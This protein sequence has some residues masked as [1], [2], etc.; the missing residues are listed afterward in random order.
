MRTLPGS[1]IARARNA[2]MNRSMVG[3][4]HGLS[5]KPGLSATGGESTV[6]SGET[7]RTDASTDL[8]RGTAHHLLRRCVGYVQDTVMTLARRIT[9][10]PGPPKPRPKPLPPDTHV[11]STAS[12][13]IGIV[14]PYNAKHNRSGGFPVRWQGGQWTICDAD[15][16]TVITIVG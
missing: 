5:V 1:R 9:I 14:Q 10:N 7:V 2:S 15:E 8:P 16:V 12:G 4:S 6:L 11:K 3:L 13:R